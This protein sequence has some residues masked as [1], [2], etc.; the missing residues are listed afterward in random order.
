MPPEDSAVPLLIPGLDEAATKKLAKRLR[1]SLQEQTGVPTLNQM[2]TLLVQAI[3]HTDWYAAQRHWDQRTDLVEAQETGEDDR[4]DQYVQSQIIR[5]NV[6]HYLPHALQAL[7]SSKRAH[8]LKSEQYEGLVAALNHLQESIPVSG[9]E[10]VHQRI[11][12]V[13]DLS[14]KYRSTHE[15]LEPFWNRAEN[16][17]FRIGE[18]MAYVSDS[19]PISE[20]LP[21]PQFSLQARANRIVDMAPLFQSCERLEGSHYKYK[22]SEEHPAVERL[23]QV[24]NDQNPK[25]PAQCFALFQ[26][27]S[28]GRRLYDLGSPESPSIFSDDFFM[29]GQYLLFERPGIETIAAAFLKGNKHNN[30]VDGHS[31][32]YLANGSLYVDTSGPDSMDMAA[33]SLLG[34]ASISSSL[35]GRRMK[36]EQTKDLMETMM[37][38]LKSTP[39]PSLKNIAY[40]F[41]VSLQT[42]QATNL[43]EASDI[44]W[45]E[46]K[47]GAYE[48]CPGSRAHLVDEVRQRVKTLQPGGTDNAFLCFANEEWNE[49]ITKLKQY[50]SVHTV[51][52][53]LRQ[54]SM[55]IHVLKG[56]AGMTGA[57]QVRKA[58]HQAEALCE[59]LA[60]ESPTKALQPWHRAHHYLKKAEALWAHYTQGIA[61]QQVKERPKPKR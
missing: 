48:K 40:D 18:F 6:D 16:H 39:P 46:E 44:Q 23:C 14:R 34:L 29:E 22:N 21:Q 49:S 25:Q 12:T 41:K 11:H 54:V 4:F 50:I 30:V 38:L 20:P 24:W 13:L 7:Q 3:G 58:L 57:A 56:L 36:L 8:S 10:D 9:F 47:W 37:T 60:E 53:N 43:V 1:K 45:L 32:C 27:S 35:G 28:D 42:L 52:N 33:E 61:N 2:Q 51:P 31:C 26:L 17:L 59:G 15:P 5:G 55:H 19:K